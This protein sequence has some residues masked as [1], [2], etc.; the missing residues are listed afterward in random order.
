MTG[1]AFAEF[2]EVFEIEVE[3]GKLIQSLASAQAA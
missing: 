1:W 2:T 3:F